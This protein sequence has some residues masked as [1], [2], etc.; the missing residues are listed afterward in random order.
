VN[1]LAQ[2]L[3]RAI[4][5]QG[6]LPVS[7]FMTLALH[8]PL[9]GF[10]AAREAI[11]ANGAFVTAPETSQIFGEL[12]GLW[13]L[14]IWRDQGRPDNVRIVEL[15]PGR[16]TLMADTLRAVRADSDFLATAEIVL[17]EASPALEAVQRE[18]LRDC[19]AVLRW[20]RQWSEVP[21]DRALFLVANEFF[22]ALAIRQYVKT[23]R[24]WC[25]RMVTVDASDRLA[26]ALA[27]MAF[28]LSIPQ[29][30]GAAEAGAVYETSP[31]AE[32]LA[33]DIAR[34]ITRHGGG[35]LL[36]DYGHAEE[37][38]G[39]TLQA[40]A[41]HNPVDVLACPGE[42]DLSAHVDFG[43]IAECAR[44]GGATV[45]GPVGQ[46][47]FLHALGIESRAALLQSAN[48]ERTA[49]I[50][51]AVSRLVEPQMMGSLFKALAIVPQGAPRPPGF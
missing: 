10:Y 20:V 43:A 48:P 18:R 41:S 12:L 3:A 9:S 28:P 45:H 49:E 33:E 46:G 16:A 40:V 50:C 30:R 29:R 26:F 11:G 15:G 39:D 14:Q 25:E 6:P 37:G 24:G 27:P 17:V 32:A 47:K 21:Q 35:A 51:D 8:D 31:A 44:A 5:H 19:G 23:E 42:A 22:D 36:V 1:A 34:A 7:V 38:F 4:R 2:R 13:L